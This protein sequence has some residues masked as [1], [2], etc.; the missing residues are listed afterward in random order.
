MADVHK[1]ERVLGKTLTWNKARINFLAKFLIAIIQ[2][3][4]VNLSEIGNSF[5]GAGKSRI[6]LQKNTTIHSSL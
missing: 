1:L 4:T 6:T 5:A 3:R 2:V